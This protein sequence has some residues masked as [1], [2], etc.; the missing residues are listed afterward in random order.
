MLIS[1]ENLSFSYEKC[2]LNNI[3]LNIEKG[4]FISI[5]G[6][7]GAGKSTLLKCMCGIIDNYS[8]NIYIDNKDLNKYRR[9]NLAQKIA[10][11]PQEQNIN[12]DFTVEEIISMGFYSRLDYFH[13]KNELEELMKETDTYSLKN[14]SI[15]SISGGEKQRVFIA[16][17]LAQKSPILFL[18]EPISNLDIRHQHQIMNL[19][20]NLSKEKN[21]TII[22]V[23]H[24]INLAS[25]YSDKIAIIKKGTLIDFNIKEKILNEELLT[26]VYDFNMEISQHKNNIIILPKTD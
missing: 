23:L 25:M 18:D 7:N 1:V 11:I 3:S 14:K 21:Y 4:E 22:S 17:A 15:N 6:P 13:I 5:I 2:I 8:G 16:R 12:F 19:C 20:K 26:D 10:Y 9:K 24:D